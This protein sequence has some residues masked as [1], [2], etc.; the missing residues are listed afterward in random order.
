VCD[1]AKA[2]EVTPALSWTKASA[3]RAI[4]ED[5]ARNAFPLYAGDEANDADALAAAAAL[6]GVAV[7]VGPNAPAGAAYR[8][9]GPDA[10]ADLLA[11]LSAALDGDKAPARALPGGASG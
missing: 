1:A 4:A 10:M 3:L 6:G 11:D 9:A 2:I 8:L 7:G 5:A